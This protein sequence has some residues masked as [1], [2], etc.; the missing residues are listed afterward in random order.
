ML[1]S[2]DFNVDSDHTRPSTL[3]SG[4]DRVVKNVHNVV[5]GGQMTESSIL[6]KLRCFGM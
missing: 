3:I 6:N 4:V 1:T 2:D 5:E